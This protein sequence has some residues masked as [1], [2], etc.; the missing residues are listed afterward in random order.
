MPPPYGRSVLL[1]AVGVDALILPNPPHVP[2]I[3]L[4]LED[5]RD[6]TLYYVPYEIVFAINKMQSSHYADQL[7]PLTGRESIFDVL[8]DLSHSLDKLR[9]TL[10]R[11]VIDEFDYD[12]SLYT[13]TAEFDLG[14]IIMK[15]RMIPSHAIYLAL[16]LGKPIYVLSSLVDQQEEWQEESGE[17]EE[18]GEEDLRP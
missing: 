3:V 4:N 9:D 16:L 12:T 13:A 8:L 11:V 5:G 17:G 18:E 1:K 10:V 2:V 7:Q 15:R 14:G 6:F